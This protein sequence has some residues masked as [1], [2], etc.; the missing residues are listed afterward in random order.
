MIYPQARLSAQQPADDEVSICEREH[1]KETVKIGEFVFKTLEDEDD[2]ACLQV[3]HNGKLVFRE[4]NLAEHYYLGQRAEGK[5]NIPAVPNGTDVTGRGHP[6]M[7]VS[8]WTGGAHC[9]SAHYVFELEPEFRLIAKLDDKDD[10]LAHFEKV[11]DRYFY[12]TADWTFAYWP[13]SFAGSPNHQVILK[14]VPDSKWGGFHLAWEEMRQPIPTKAGWNAALNDVHDALKED[15][16]QRED[17][18]S[19][20]WN[21]VLDLIYTGHSNLAWKFVEE[22]GP[23]AQQGNNASLEDFCSILKTSLYWSDLEPTLRNTPAVCTSAKPR[24]NRR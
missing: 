11:G 15:A 19:T 4:A 18:G 12:H 8:Y 7:I 10:D 2:P 13:G 17:L 14:F 16:M 6:D 23:K 24:E 9:C 1:P 21:T 3:F 22:A 5:W 20:L